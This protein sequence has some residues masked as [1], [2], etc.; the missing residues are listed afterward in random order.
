MSHQEWVSRLSR[1]S[2]ALISD[3]LR[4]AG[5]PHQVLHHSI[6]KLVPGPMVVGPAFCVRG[7]RILGGVP[8]RSS[9]NPRFEMYRR[10]Q[11]GAVVVVESGG[12]EDAVMFGDN[13]AHGFA[14]RQCAGIVTDGGIRDREAM[15]GLG[16]PVFG[17]F[18]TPLSS[19]GQWL[20]TELE[21]PLKLKGQSSSYVT[22][23]PGD[24]IV[25][26]GDGVIVIPE[27]CVQTVAEDAQQLADIEAEI[28]RRLATG[29]DPGEVFSA[30]D[31]AKHVR[32]VV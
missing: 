28:G 18:T 14:V 21:V 2:T 17:R 29:Q 9:A 6:Q 16:M 23:N 11:A 22:V 25:A 24:F 31:R 7:E 10:V 26:D 20:M 27:A 1:V 12:Y 8:K 30:F 4:T 13:I 15:A 19:G 32:R 5:A 3:V